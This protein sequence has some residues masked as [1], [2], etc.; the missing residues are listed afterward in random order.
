[1][2]TILH[3]IPILAAALAA[4]Q[5]ARALDLQ[6]TRVQG[7]VLRRALAL[8][9]KGDWTGAEALARG[10]NDVVLQDIVLWRKLRAG[11]GTVPEYQSFVS[12]RG[13]WPGLDSLA[14]AVLG[15]RPVPD[16]G[17][18]MLTPQARAKWDAF[19]RLM[20]SRD[21]DAAERFLDGVDASELGNPGLWAERRAMLVRRA[22]REGRG[23]RAYRIATRHGLTPAAGYDYS[24]LEWLAGWTALRR[25]G[26]PKRAIAHFERFEAT[27]ETPIS[28]GRAG[29]WL[30]RAH[31]AA[32]DPAA[33][34][35]AYARA[36][37]HQTSFYGQL[38]AAA[39]GAPGDP[40]LTATDLPDWEK[41]PV[42][43]TDDVRMAAIVHFAGE[44]SL[45][46]Q[47]FTHLSRH[48]EG[49]AALGAL[50]DLALAL[51]RPHYAVR[52]A[53]NA[54]R[55]GHVL[56]PAYYPLTELAQYASAVEPALAMSIARQETELNPAAISPAGARGLMQVM[57][58][59]AKK[60]ASWIGEDYSEPRL[61]AD[62]RYNARL[63]HTYLSRRIEEFGGSYVLAA[64]AYNAGKGRV[65]EWIGTNG[66]PRLPGTDIID[67]IEDIPFSETRNYV[68]RVIE[69]LYVYR[70]RLAGQVGQ[71]TI[72]DDLAR[73]G[74]CQPAA[75]LSC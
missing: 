57:P 41:S 38:A 28:L 54:T 17:G 55:K 68:Q 51:D 64:A 44:D 42:T 39:I 11:S 34:Q 33:A 36:A 7:E 6:E 24:D 1:M 49:G 16:S 22:V 67:W 29:Y 60:V 30:G 47:A 27:V 75:T 50:A 69:G 62:W 63:G 5:A 71:M 8:G 10:T 52:I 15:E 32:G 19:D 65:D 70:S 46:F 9:E 61:T 66:D 58:A 56:M 59:T 73:G 35:A 18:S 3:A 72:L 45:A 13:T 4:P 31:E 21:Y 74:R 48:I 14:E 20:K 53:K 43:R 12:R 40:A 23:E 2:R 37:Q 25:L 26:D